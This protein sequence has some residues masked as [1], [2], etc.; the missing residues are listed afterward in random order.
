MHRVLCA[1][2]FLQEMHATRLCPNVNTY[3]SVVNHL[4]KHKQIK[5]V[6]ASIRT[7]E[8][9]SI[10]ADVFTQNILIIGLLKIDKLKDTQVVDDLLMREGSVDVIT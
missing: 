9:Q 6:K 1:Q 7:M 10:H 2:K 3:N 5:D 4:F 8:G